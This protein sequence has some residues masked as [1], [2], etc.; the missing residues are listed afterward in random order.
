MMRLAA[1]LL[2]L[3]LNNINAPQASTGK[4]LHVKNVDVIANVQS[5]DVEQTQKKC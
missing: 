1:R 3:I 2:P 5:S 4:C